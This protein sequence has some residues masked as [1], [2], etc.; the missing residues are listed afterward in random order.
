MMIQAICSF[1][2]LVSIFLLSFH[3]EVK[4]LGLGSNLN[5]ALIVL[6]GTFFATLL[7]YPFNKL[8]MTGQFLKQSFSGNKQIDW[9]I[10]TLVKLA[11]VHKKSGIRALEREGEKLPSGSHQY[12]CGPHGL[13][14]QPGKYGADFT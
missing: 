1:F 3:L 9:T 12:R 7:A 5:A 13:Q 14:F 10:E 2:V 4:E 8:V 6:G 11:R